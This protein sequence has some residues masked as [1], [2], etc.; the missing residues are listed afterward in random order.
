MRAAPPHSVPLALELEGAQCCGATSTDSLTFAGHVFASCRFT[1]RTCASLT[2]SAICASSP[3]S[4]LL[5]LLR[6]TASRLPLPLLSRPYLNHALTYIVQLGRRRCVL[7][8]DLDLDSSERCSRTLPAGT[9]S[10]SIAL[11]LL[12]GQASFSLPNSHPS[13][14]SFDARLALAPRPV[15]PTQEARAASAR[16]SVRRLAGQWARVGVVRRR[17][18][19]RARR[20]GCIAG[21]G[22]ARRREGGARRDDERGDDVDIE[23]LARDSLSLELSV[24]ARA[25]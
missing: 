15:P 11:D 4:D 25:C 6:L 1:R 13:P 17:G 8:F 21:A 2:S 19:C 24:T 16:R 10:S 12:H 18:A 5:K 9:S 14:L 3:H 7:A 22:R 20:C 23:L